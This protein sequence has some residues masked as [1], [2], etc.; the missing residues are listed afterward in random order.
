MAPPGSRRWAYVRVMAGTILGGVL[1]FYVMHRIETSYKARRIQPCPT[2]PPLWLW[3]ALSPVSSGLAQHFSCRRGWRR[4][5][6]GTRRICSPKPRSRSSCRTRYSGRIKP[7][8]CPTRDTDI[9][10]LLRLLF[11]K[12]LGTSC[13]Y[14]LPFPRDHM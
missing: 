1:G 13:H 3:L 4:G 9:L 7:S 6:G 11:S 8:S 14:W 10:P 2:P 5:C 12:L